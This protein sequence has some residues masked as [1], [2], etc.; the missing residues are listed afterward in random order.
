MRETHNYNNMSHSAS[1][2]FKVFTQQ[3]NVNFSAM[4][5]TKS[6]FLCVLYSEIWNF[7]CFHVQGRLGSQQFLKSM[8][9]NST[10]YEPQEAYS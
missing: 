7:G 9:R 2:M 1:L 3:P 5:L 8:K 4:A 10:I 6:L